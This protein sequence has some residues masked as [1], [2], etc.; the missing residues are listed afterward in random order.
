L[1][2]YLSLYNCIVQKVDTFFASS[3]IC[4]KCDTKNPDVKDLSVREWT[5]ECGSENDRDLN[6]SFNILQE[7]KKQLAN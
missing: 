3:Q 2:T 7:G 4:N 1:K 6:A 5:C